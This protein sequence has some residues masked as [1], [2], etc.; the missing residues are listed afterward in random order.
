MALAEPPVCVLFLT[1][2]PTLSIVLGHTANTDS[3]N[4]QASFTV[5]STAPSI[6]PLIQPVA[7]QVGNSNLIIPPGSFKHN[8]AGYTFTGV[9]NG[10]SLN[11]QISVSG[12]L[13]YTF[14]ATAS[15]AN[16]TGLKTRCQWG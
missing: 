15:G 10:V 12:T 2:N 3:Y 6:N 9:I 4:F 16:L 14:A 11:V 8:D 7:I 1:F 5:S 13:R